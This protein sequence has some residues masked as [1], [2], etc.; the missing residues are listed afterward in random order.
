MIMYQV[1]TREWLYDS[2]RYTAEGPSSFSLRSVTAL[3]MRLR[4]AEM[5]RKLKTG[6]MDAYRPEIRALGGQDGEEAEMWARIVPVMRDCWAGDPERRPRVSAI[7][8]IISHM[9]A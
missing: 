5:M 4:M 9:T 8:K 6:D 3:L 7:R 2:D 1:M